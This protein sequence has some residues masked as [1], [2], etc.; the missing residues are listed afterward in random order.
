MRQ[1]LDHALQLYDKSQQ[2]LAQYQRESIELSRALTTRE[3][4]LGEL[5][6]VVRLLERDRDASKSESQALESRIEVER[7]HFEAKL[8]SIEQKVS[9]VSQFYLF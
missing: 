2:E 8:G 9:F 3:E 7:R 6:K 4:R 5:E 1:E